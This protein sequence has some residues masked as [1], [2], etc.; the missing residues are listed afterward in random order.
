MAKDPKEVIQ[1]LK[2]EYTR[3]HTDNI[4]S[5][6]DAYAQY[7]RI[8]S[9]A[10]ADTVDT[11]T[12]VDLETTGLDPQ[13]DDI[14]E[15][16]VAITDSNLVLIDSMVHVRAIDDTIIAKMTDYV[17]HMHS[18]NGLISACTK[19]SKA[20]SLEQMDIEVQSFINK[21]RKIN[22]TKHPICGSSPHY[23]LAF[24]GTQM[25]KTR[26]MF[27]HRTFDTSNMAQAIKLV[28]SYSSPRTDTNVTGE[29]HRAMYDIRMSILNMARHLDCLLCRSGSYRYNMKEVGYYERFAIASQE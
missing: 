3:E 18:V 12:W 5:L 26:G 10:F 25:P 19:S 27:N 28:K 14:L 20:I 1:Y 22:D 4:S 21:Y 6:I 29:P 8:N 16:A 11:Y 9:R 17:K 24:L 2:D 7:S 13:K 23:D 15:I